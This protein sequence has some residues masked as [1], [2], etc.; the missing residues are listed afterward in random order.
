MRNRRNT[1]RLA[2]SIPRLS[3]MTDIGRSSIYAEIAAGR[4]IDAKVGRRTIILRA[5]ALAWLR[6]LRRC[7]TI[8]PQ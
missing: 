3:K 7:P 5:D 6:S 2:Y 1:S 8:A 4:L